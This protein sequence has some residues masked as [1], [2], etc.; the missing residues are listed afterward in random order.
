MRASFQGLI[1]LPSK[2]FGDLGGIP[3]E[4]QASNLRELHLCHA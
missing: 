3:L 1:L 2:S 4:A